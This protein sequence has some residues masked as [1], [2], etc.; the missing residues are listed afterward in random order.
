MV[1]RDCVEKENITKIIEENI[2]CLNEIS[3]QM[4]MGYLSI[5]AGA[6][7]SVSSGYVDWKKL[8]S[9][10]CR[11]MRLDSS[12]DLTEIAQFYK[13][14]YGRQGLNNILF[15]EFS[16]IP[17]NN[18]NVEILARLP[19]KSY[20]TTNYDDVIETELCKRGK[21]VHKVEFQD[22][23]KYH[24]PQ[25]DVTLYKMHGDREHPDN[26]VLTKEDYQDYDKKR[27]LFTRLLA[28]ELVRKTFLFIGFSFNDPNL[29][30]I[31]SMAKNSVD[32]FTISKHYC[33]M[34]RVQP[35]DYLDE[36]YKI[37]NDNFLKFISDKNYQELKIENLKKNYNVITI[38]V[39][40]FDQITY[41]LQY[42]YDKHAMNNVF[43]SG[44]INPKVLSDYGDFN[45]VQKKMKGLN[46]A[47]SFL[48]LLGKKL[49]ENNYTIY[50]GFGAGVGNYILSGVLSEHSETIQ[51]LEAM[52]KR[53]YICNMINL[54]EEQ[55]NTIRERMI[56]QCG[57]TI[58][59]FGYNGNKKKLGGVYREF[60]CSRK[61][62]SFVIPV[63]ATGFEAANIYK[64]MESILGCHEEYRILN[65]K[66]Y[67]IELMVD[68][69]IN[70]LNNN[71]L[72]RE[73]K[74]NDRLFNSIATYG[75][76]VFISYYYKRDNDIAKQ[77]IEIVNHDR[78]NQFTVIQEEKK[79]HDCQEIKRW[80]DDQLEKTQITIILISRK[81]LER[82]YVSYE[83]RKSV[84]KGKTIIPIIIDDKNN[85]FNS[86][87]LSEIK[88]RLF[89]IGINEKTTIR[90]W[91]SENGS[92]NIVSW[93]YKAFN[94]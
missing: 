43:V 48:T 50:T 89:T 6:G 22:S 69:I 56:E 90:K 31:L 55:K 39:D 37:S 78:F 17:K 70:L 80:V 16:K 73:S 10:I 38:L 49:I 59:V 2:Q 91:Y 41:M 4:E 74:L 29:E 86:K 13:D 27:G 1:Y 14:K 25:I 82:R 84:K 66:N 88:K 71:R 72:K 45:N 94:D 81:T 11:L 67:D 26:I 28:V 33:F 24:D 93:L 3:E 76:R 5:F 57:S 58:I 12:V 8:L 63:A 60:L 87:D 79:N 68:T 75:I 61:N 9:P 44:G 92:E 64:E 53:I 18:K 36:N 20:W 30:R 77:I 42:L 32:S 19:I 51:K 40:D 52:N 47:Q 34:R 7:L 21:A 46:R 65:N 54:S 23:F 62:N 85:K 83:L 35:Y 15:K